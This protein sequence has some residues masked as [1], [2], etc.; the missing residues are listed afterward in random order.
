[1]PAGNVA[2][3][4]ILVY[5]MITEI[6]QPETYRER[7]KEPAVLFY[8]SHD[9]CNVCKVLKPKVHEMLHREYPGMNMYYINIH[10]LPELAGQERIFTVPTILICFD[11]KEM[12]RRSR[13][14][15]IDELSSLIRRPY[16]LF[17][18]QE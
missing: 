6:L 1:V 11:G 4:F 17:F 5:A 8:F 14:V 10:T 15:G 18:D 3:R 7:K 12:Y 9:D 2:I 13:T 16:N